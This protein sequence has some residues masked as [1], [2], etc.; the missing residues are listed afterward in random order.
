MRLPQAALLA[1]LTLLGCGLPLLY[2][3]LNLPDR[4]APPGSAAYAVYT[5]VLDTLT[6]GASSQDV[7]DVNAS[8]LPDP[9][10]EKAAPAAYRDIRAVRAV[11]ADRLTYRFSTRLPVCLVPFGANPCGNLGLFGVYSLSPVSFNADT[12]HAFVQWSKRADDYG[13]GADFYLAR[14]PGCAWVV[15]RQTHNWLTRR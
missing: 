4:P 1:P 11:S 7:I 5:A 9:F 3:R 10:V 13:Y 8:L 2:P 12:T 14:R 15:A 6:A